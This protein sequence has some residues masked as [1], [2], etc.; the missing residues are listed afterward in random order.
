MS[1]TSSLCS[2][3]IFKQFS[4]THTFI[5]TISILFI[6]LTCSNITK[7]F[8][9]TFTSLYYTFF[10][11]GYYLITDFMVYL[12]KN[13]INHLFL[14]LFLVFFLTFLHLLEM[15]NVLYY[16]F[17]DFTFF[18]SFFIIDLSN[19]YFFFFLSKYQK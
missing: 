9:L 12:Y 19:R 13:V 10:Y 1:I 5:Y 3:W 6:T 7:L 11:S 2:F 15:V 17:Y 8:I 16:S 18:I 4:R 14:V